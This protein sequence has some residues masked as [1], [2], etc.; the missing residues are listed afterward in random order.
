[1]DL[2]FDDDF[3]M[4]GLIINFQHPHSLEVPNESLNGAIDGLPLGFSYHL[5]VGAP[6]ARQPTFPA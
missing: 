2:T 6:D 5:T 1:M 4:V 3:F